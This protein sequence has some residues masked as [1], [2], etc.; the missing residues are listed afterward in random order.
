LS[1]RSVRFVEFRVV[2]L[3]RIG[4]QEIDLFEIFLCSCNV[5]LLGIVYVDFYG[6]GV[7]YFFMLII[8]I[9]YIVLVMTF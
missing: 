8:F 6:V 2:K 5:A 4:Y 7:F 3:L 1:V 9:L